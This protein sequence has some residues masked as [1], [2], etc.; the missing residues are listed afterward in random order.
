MYRVVYSAHGSQHV[1]MKLSKKQTE[2]YRQAAMWVT[3]A[4]KGWLYW[5]AL[6]TATTP[7][8][9][10]SEPRANPSSQQHELY[11]PIVAATAFLPVLR[12]EWRLRFKPHRVLVF[13]ILSTFFST[14]DPRRPL[15]PPPTPSL[16]DACP[17]SSRAY[18]N[19][20]SFSFSFYFY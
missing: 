3:G 18:L 6:H 10:V 11:N 13:C 14:S 15:S 19:C 7:F 2:E 8:R 16:S 12:S 20:F 17:L 4:Y 5:S 1:Q 9:R